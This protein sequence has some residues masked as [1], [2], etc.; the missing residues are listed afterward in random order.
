MQNNMTDE[1]E[2]KAVVDGLAD[3]A[4]CYFCGLSVALAETRQIKKF[5]SGCVKTLECWRFKSLNLE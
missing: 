2:A 3:V 5:R 1:E 4:Q